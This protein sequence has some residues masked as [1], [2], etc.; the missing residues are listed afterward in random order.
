MHG[1]K[2]PDLPDDYII[3]KFG[4]AVEQSIASRSSDTVN[5]HPDNCLLYARPCADPGEAERRLKHT[6]KAKK[7]RKT[8][9]DAKGKNH[10]ELVVFRASDAN[11]IRRLIDVAIASV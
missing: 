11:M 9:K 6:L 10:T 3:A 1:I 5:L 2:I 8:G 4:R 7:L